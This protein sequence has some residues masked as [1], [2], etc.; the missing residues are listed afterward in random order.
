MH[1]PWPATP[2]G[3]ASL[4]VWPIA[5][6][7][8]LLRPSSGPPPALRWPSSGPPLALFRPSSGPP[9]ALLWPSS[10]PPLTLPSAPPLALPSAQVEEIHLNHT[11]LLDTDNGRAW[12]PN[13]VL[14]D[15]PFINLST[16]GEAA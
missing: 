1:L 3:S 11:R 5:G 7:L 12:W 8:A 2:P 10:G 15:T 4:T 6:P 13:K 14:R 9:P 16:S